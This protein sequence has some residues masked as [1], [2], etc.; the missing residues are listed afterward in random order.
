MLS[1]FEFTLSAPLGTKES[2]ILPSWKD[3]CCFFSLRHKRGAGIGIDS[4]VGKEAALLCGSSPDSGIEVSL[5]SPL[6]RRIL[7]V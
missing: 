1:T 4:L 7:D 2:S 3:G 5:D 6:Q